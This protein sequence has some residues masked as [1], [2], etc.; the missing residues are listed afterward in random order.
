MTDLEIL[1]EILEGDRHGIDW[2]CSLI[3][4]LEA[5]HGKEV[6]E[7]IISAIGTEIDTYHS[8][9]E[10]LNIAKRALKCGESLEVVIQKSKS[11]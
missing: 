6:L 11:Y 5:E 9:A 2:I 7:K 8:Y 3:T 4:E 10:R 1:K